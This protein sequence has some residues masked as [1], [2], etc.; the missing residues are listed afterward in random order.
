M[1]PS[2]LNVFGV[3]AAIILI[4]F[5]R[6]LFWFF[7]GIAGF[8]YGSGI[9]AQYFPSLSWLISVLIGTVV[10]IVCALMAPYFQ[11]FLVAFAGFII[12]AYTAVW[13]FM[14]WVPSGIDAIWIV[15]LAGG[16]LGFLL[17]WRLLDTALIVLSALLGAVFLIELL[18][19]VPILNQM[20]GLAAL[21]LGLGVQ[22]QAYQSAR[23]SSSPSNKTE[24]GTRDA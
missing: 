9:V 19:F 17:A 13:L 18:P 1:T 14:R 24:P 5:G 22:I 2:I 16:V 23:Q 4:F 8:L 12:G 15:Y 20:A 3:L 11:R 7:V 21:V 10:G 6:K